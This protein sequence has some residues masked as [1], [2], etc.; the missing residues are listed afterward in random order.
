[1]NKRKEV[2]KKNRVLLCK[3]KKSLSRRVG[4]MKVIRECFTKRLSRER[5]L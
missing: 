4:K 3:K 2:K 1:M 5:G